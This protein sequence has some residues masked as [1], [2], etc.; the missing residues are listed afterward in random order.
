[1]LLGSTV[2]LR[3]TLRPGRGAADRAGRAVPVDG[4]HPGHA[5]AHPGARRPSSSTRF[6]LAGVEV[7]ASSGSALPATLA[8]AWMD[9][10]GDNLYNIYG[11]TEV[12]YASIATPEDLRADPTSAGRPPHG[13]VVKILDEEGREVPQGETGPD[14]RR[15]RAAVRGLHP[16]RVQ[17]G[18]RRTDVVG[19][20]RLVRRGR[21]AARRGSRR[22]HDRLRRRERLPAGGRGLPGRPRAGARGRCRRRRRRGLWS[23]S[24]RL[25]GAHRQGVGRRAARAREG[26]PGA[27]QGAARDRVRRRAAAQRHRQGPQAGAGRVASRTSRTTTGTSGRTAS[28]RDVRGTVHRRRGTRLHPA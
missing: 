11:S 4:R 17:G 20:R 12:A 6:D 8:Q 26:Q 5:A 23:A 27:V 25:R 16:R 24:A 15:Q 2:V 3:R 14:L 28:R 1:M 19:R 10:F 21:S 13:T 7:V 9:R 18:R 22:R